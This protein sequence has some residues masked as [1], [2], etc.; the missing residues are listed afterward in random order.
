MNRFALAML[1][2]SSSFASPTHAAIEFWHSDTV[3]ANQGM[4]SATFTFDSFS[5]EVNNLQVW[6]STIYKGKK[7]KLGVL[8]VEPFGTSSADRYS[9][10]TLTS[11]A[12]CGDLTLIVDKATAV[13]NGKRVDLLKAKAIST[14]D[15]KPFKIRIGK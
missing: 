11:E 5:E 14:K 4:C 1:F 9:Y 8:E 13:E 3:W 12:M 7:E 10:A 15:F 6:V 2:A